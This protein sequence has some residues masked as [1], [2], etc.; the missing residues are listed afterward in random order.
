MNDS[1]VV[2]KIQGLSELKDGW[3]GSGAPAIDPACIAGACAFVLDHENNYLAEDGWVYPTTNGGVAF[4]W[5]EGRT[6]GIAFNPGKALP[7]ICVG[8]AER[9]AE[10]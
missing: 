10:K 4:E 3:D 9:E 6:I 8:E 5:L 7:Q 1:E 2:E